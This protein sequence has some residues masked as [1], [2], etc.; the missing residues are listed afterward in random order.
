M[1]KITLKSGL[2]LSEILHRTVLPSDTIARVEQYADYKALT[3]LSYLDDMGIPVFAIIHNEIGNAYWGKGL[4]TEFAKA[5]ALM[6]FVERRNASNPDRSRIIHASYN[7]ICDMAVSR[8]DLI[9]TNIQRELYTKEVYDSIDI[10]WYPCYSLFEDKEVYIPASLVCLNA[11]RDFS[12][13]EDTNGL[14]SGNTMEEAVIHGLCELIERHSF[15]IYYYNKRPLEL[16]DPFSCS[17]GL[18]SELVENLSKKGFSFYLADHTMG[19]PVPVVSLILKRDGEYPYKAF[20]YM[21]S[22][23]C[24]PHPEVAFLRCITEIAQTRTRYFYGKAV[25]KEYQARTDKPESLFNCELEKRMQIKTKK[26]FDKMLSISSRDIKTELDIILDYLKKKNLGVYI[27]DLTSED[28]PI[29][30]I[31]V[32]VRNLQPVISADLNVDDQFSRI[33]VYLDK[34]DAIEKFAEKN[35]KERIENENRIIKGDCEILKLRLCH[36]YKTIRDYERG[37]EIAEDLYRQSPES[38]E[39]ALLYGELLFHKKRYAES[40]EV[41][42][43]LLKTVMDRR[44]IIA[45]AYHLVEIYNYMHNEQKAEGY[46]DLILGLY[47]PNKLPSETEIREMYIK[48]QVIRLNSE[49]KASELL[50]EK[51]KS[52]YTADK[53]FQLYFQKRDYKRALLYAREVVDQNPELLFGWQHLIDSYKASDDNQNAV[54]TREKA[55]SYFISLG[56]SEEKIKKIF[57]I[58]E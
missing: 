29:P 25:F 57:E 32:I 30:T 14:A 1:D 5:S 40:S 48:I 58:K 26:R 56:Y 27:A 8:F 39:Y 53:L 18:I 6:E 17:I 12:D 50:Y 9:P 11:N 52:P 28:V 20:T 31:R 36:L 2:I 16:I 3:D 35:R 37:L 44:D 55:V 45:C 7:D 42:E 4:N 49:I 24:H 43:K 22:P 46:I 13:R 21:S 51:E 19:L 10:D 38:K 34:Y 15:D 47:P 41:F 23:G 33:S 54:K